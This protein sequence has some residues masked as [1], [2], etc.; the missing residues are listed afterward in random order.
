MMEITLTCS[1]CGSAINILPS[2]QAHKAQCQVCEHQMDVS[3]SQEHEKGQLT[4]CPCC[5]R[6]DFYSQKDFNRK[7]GVILFVVAAIASLWTYGLS[8]VALYL[9]D[10]FLFRKLKKIAICYKCQAVFRNTSN[11]DAICEFNHEM[12]D[13][14]IYSNHDFGGQKLDH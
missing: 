9:L 14:I 5:Q 3:F 11:I 8:L 4:Q 10:L 7:I 6:K 1:H 13:R 12:N 2:R